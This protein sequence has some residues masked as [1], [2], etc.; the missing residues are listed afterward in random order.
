[1]L[2][3][4]LGEPTVPPPRPF[5]GLRVIKQ[6]DLNYITVRYL[7][8]RGQDILKVLQIFRCNE[9]RHPA[10]PT[11]LEH[12]HFWS[13]IPNRPANADCASGVALIQVE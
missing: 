3:F 4:L 2:D 7:E 10:G 12:E 13:Q 11:S 1:M 9:N 5:G 6:A 8:R